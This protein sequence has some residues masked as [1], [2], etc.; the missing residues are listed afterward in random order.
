MGLVRFKHGDPL[1][2][3][4]PMVDFLF[5]DDPKGPELVYSMDEPTFHY[6]D[7]CRIPIQTLKICTIGIFRFKHEDPLVLRM[8]M[9]DFLF[10]DD[11]KGSELVYSMDEPTFHYSDRC[12]IPIQTLKICTMGIVRFKHGDPLVLRMP[13]VNFLFIDDPK[14]S[15]LVYSMDEPTFHYQTGV[16]YQS[17]PIKFALWVLLGSNMGIHWY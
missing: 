14:G 4:M 8:P 12:R 6:P 10:I 11:P 15:E 3:R 17:R 7:R 1:V 9:V 16:E 13:M 5:I 2:L